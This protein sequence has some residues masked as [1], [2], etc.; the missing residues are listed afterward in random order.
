EAAA[1]YRRRFRRHHERRSRARLHRVCYASRSPRRIE[2]RG[3]RAGRPLSCRRG[4]AML[5]IFLVTAGFMFAAT[6]CDA[7]T[8]RLLVGGSMH[9]PFKEVG[10]A[11]SKKTGNTLDFV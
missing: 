2:G 1:L 4:T 10:A 8:I 11:F 7:A 3:C 6:Q 5:K 9:E